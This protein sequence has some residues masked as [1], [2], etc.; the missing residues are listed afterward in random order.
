MATEQQK[1][2]LT[3]TRGA[4]AAQI[5]DP[6]EK[7]AYIAGSANVDK[8]Y[9]ST[10]NATVVKSNELQRRAILGSMH[11][12]GPVMADGAYNLKAGEHVLTAPEAAKAKKHALMASGIKSLAKAGKAAKKV[13]E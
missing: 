12:G 13:K 8:D 6:T 10:A 4:Q 11:T 2:S 7:K 5:K 9:D 1:A 3:Q